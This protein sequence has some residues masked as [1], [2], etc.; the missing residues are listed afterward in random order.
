MKKSII[1][2][3]P[4]LKVTRI[5]QEQAMNAKV[6]NTGSAIEPFYLTKQDVIRK[7]T[8]SA[9][10]LDRLESN[11]RF[12]KRIRINVNKAVWIYTDIHN[13]CILVRNLKGYPPVGHY[14]Y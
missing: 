11:G 4:I 9:S 14:T 3:H 8:V 12:P 2:K 10:S 5:K 7:T 6:K 1:A 13:W